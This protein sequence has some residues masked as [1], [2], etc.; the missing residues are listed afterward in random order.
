MSINLNDLIGIPYKDHGRDASGYD[1]YGLAIEV[2]RRYGY[3]LNDVI[4]T[5]HNL[6]LSAENVPTLNV[7][8]IDAPREGAILE[9]EYN[10]N[11][12][13]GVAINEREFIH[14]TRKG[15]RIN[16]IGVYKIRGIYGINTRI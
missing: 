7:T 10:N 1:C 4:Y 2:A 16:Q 14:M 12:H 3:K 11:L 8:P 13:I 6:E 15:C 9:M 5:D